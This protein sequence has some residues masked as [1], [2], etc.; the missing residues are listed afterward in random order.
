MPALVGPVGWNAPHD[1]ELSAAVEKGRSNANAPRDLSP[2]PLSLPAR[3]VQKDADDL[4]IAG[5]Q[6][7]HELVPKVPNLPS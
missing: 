1:V 5:K 6:S 3:P 4:K 2:A 7:R